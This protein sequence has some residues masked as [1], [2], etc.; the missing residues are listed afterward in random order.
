MKN[1]KLII[2]I[3]IITILLIGVVGITFAIY[4]YSR[5]SDN[6]ELIVGDIYMRYKETRSL[7]IENAVP[8]NTYDSTKYFQFE[9]T[10]KNT[11]TNKDIWY[12]ILLNRGNVPDGK[13]EANRIQDKFIKFRL[14]ELV[15]NETTHELEENEIFTNK[16]FRDLSTGKRIHVAT[17]PRNTRSNITHTYRLYM[18]ISNDV[19]IGNTG[20]E[21]IDYDMTTWSN[22]FASIIVSSTGDFNEK[23]I[24]EDAT[25]AS[26]FTTTLNTRYTLNDNMTQEELQTCVDFLTS[27]GFPGD[28]TSFCEGT[29][30]IDGTLDTPTFQ[31]LLYN[32]VNNVFA[33]DEL[34]YLLEHNIISEEGEITITRYDSSC[35]S[36]VVIPST[37]PHISYTLNTNMT[38]E[39]L[40]TCVNYL[41]N[42][43]GAEAPINYQAYCEGTG[44]YHFSTF[45]EE[46]DYNGFDT[47]DLDYFLAHNIITAPASTSNLVVTGIG[48]RAF[49]N[50][51]LTS[52]TIPNSVTQYYCNS[53]DSNVEIIKEN[54]DLVCQS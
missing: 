48:E 15:E 43:W 49:E 12:D 40:Q 26:C 25:D 54:E 51:N 6:Q 36:E 29:G 8:S 14:T 19:R 45:Q 34:E 38:Q 28:A 3:S 35:G 31:E 33:P 18:W 21:G 44:A 4:Q 46:L 16:S 11:T 39:E 5:I 32:N 52:V 22:L 17:I 10:G 27:A 41:K 37:L 9:I 23:E 53:F 2:L 7:S 50:K 13:T 24:D 47:D 1:N 20:N 30:T 42:K